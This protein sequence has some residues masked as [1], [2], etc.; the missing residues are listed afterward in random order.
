MSAVTGRPSGAVA[1]GGRGTFAGKMTGS[2]SAPRVEGRFTGDQMR[3]WDVLWGQGIADLVIEGGYVVIANSR[4]TKG[5]DAQITADGRYAL[6]FRSDTAEEIRATVNMT[7]WPIADLR[8]AFVL[9]EWPMDGTVGAL[10]LDLSGRYKNMFGSGRMRIDRGRAWDEPFDTATADIELEGSGMR[11]NRIEM[12]KGPGLVRGAA[13]LGWRDGTYAFNADGERVAVESL[14]NFKFEKAPLSGVMRFRATGAGLFESP[15]Y[16]V[17]ATVADLFVADEGI[18]QVTGRFT[19][20]NKVL[21]FE[22]LTAASNRLQVSGSGSIQLNDASDADLQFRFQQTSIDPY[23]RLLAPA[24][25]PYTRAIVSGSLEARGPL[26]D[27]SKVRATMTIDSSQLTLFDYELTNDGPVQ[28]VYDS[29]VFTVGRLRLRGLDTDLQLGGSVDIGQS[30]YNLSATGDVSLAILQLRYPD[31]TASGGATVKAQ[32]TGPFDR[33]QISGEATIDNGRLRMYALQHSLDE[34]NGPIRFDGAGINVDGLRARMGG[35][36]ILFGGTIGM[37]NMQFT[38]FSLTANGQLMQLRYPV[39]FTSTVNADLS[40]TGTLDAMHLGG[41][42]DV[43]ATRYEGTLESNNGLLGLAAGGAMGGGDALPTPVATAPTTGIPLTMG[44][45]VHIPSTNIIQKGTTRVEASGDLTLAGT[46]D[47]P[48][49][50]GR[51]NIEGGQFYFSGNRYLVR[52]GSIEFS[53]LTRIEPVFDLEAE[54]NPR[55]AGQTFRVTV[56]L[57]GTF[58]SFTQSLTSEPWLSEADAVAL[59]LGASP[60]L[61]RELARLTPQ[62]SQAR[63]LQTL[64]AQLLT[65]PLTGRVGNV[66]TDALPI[67]TVQITPVLSNETAFQNLNPSA[68]VTIGQR[69]SSR[70]YL[71]YSRS[72]AGAQNEIILLEYDQS[73]RVSWVLSRNED[74]TFALDFRLRFVFR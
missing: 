19:I 15:S 24:Y 4:I 54:T 51:V 12:R 53:S 10:S 2:F 3:A 48:S 11:V 45:D 60:N 46:F 8:H 40:L 33:Q 56:R 7:G 43:I 13:R 17:E 70:I 27:V 35:G 30:R 18:G 14:E 62:Q 72:I 36:P 16:E 61:D 1:V 52:P 37:S 57:T 20:R 34:I 26:S 5:P 74:R 59:L 42:V 25:S 23:L 65:S 50:L 29:Q 69:I 38:Q 64:G 31:L 68:R 44:V 9:D 71:T 73:D 63:L 41:N 58:N 55:A 6:G 66:V 28:L 49:L 67:D 21:T 32:L 47:R 22:R 39:G